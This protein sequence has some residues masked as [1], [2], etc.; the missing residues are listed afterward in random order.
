MSPVINV[1]GNPRNFPM[2][3]LGMDNQHELLGRISMSIRLDKNF[4]ASP[5]GLPA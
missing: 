2:A 1:P 5:S 3:L 4:I